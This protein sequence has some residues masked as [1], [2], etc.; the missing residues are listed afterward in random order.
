MSPPDE[1]SMEKEEQVHLHFR[2]GIVMGLLEKAKEMVEAP[3]HPTT[4]RK[5]GRRPS[6]EGSEEDGSSGS[7]KKKRV[8]R[9]KRDDRVVPMQVLSTGHHF[10][11]PI[12]DGER[13]RCRMCTI[14]NPNGG[15]KTRTRCGGCAKEGYGAVF[16]HAKCFELYHAG[17]MAV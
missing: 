12:P 10:P 11:V 2:Q 3:Q 14:L 9:T 5:R 8:R 16:L 4:T 1:E 17:E 7:G 6:T 13:K 15:G